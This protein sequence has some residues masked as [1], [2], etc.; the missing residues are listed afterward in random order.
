MPFS[1]FAWTTETAP[2]AYVQVVTVRVSPTGAWPGVRPPTLNTSDGLAQEPADHVVVVDRVDHDLEARGLEHPRPRRQSVQML[3][4][5]DIA[6]TS[7]IQPSS[8][9]R[10]A[11]AM[12]SS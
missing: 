4:V 2:D 1:W 8:T 5:I 3:T 7:P 12:P 9:I 11:A 10:C 6:V